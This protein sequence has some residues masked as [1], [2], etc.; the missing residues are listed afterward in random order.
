MQNMKQPISARLISN[1]A[2]HKFLHDEIVAVADGLEAVVA[3]KAA[4]K[5]VEAAQMKAAIEEAKEAAK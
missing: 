1:K 4:E 2:S 5:A 3:Q